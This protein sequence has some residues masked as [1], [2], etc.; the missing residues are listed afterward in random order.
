MEEG[1][2]ISKIEKMSLAQR[3]LIYA[4]TLVFLAGLFVWLVALPK[5]EQIQREKK[6]VARLRERLAQARIRAKDLHK[7]RAE[8]KMIDA[9]FREALRLLPNKKEIPQLLR[10]ITQLGVDSNLEFIYFSPKKER[11]RDF[12]IEIPIEMKVRGRYHD[13]ATFFYKLAKM[14]RIVRILDFSMRPIAENSNVLLAQCS[15][16]TYRFKGN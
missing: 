16:I 13:I 3:I 15:A 4:G 10:N 6:E 7:F 2:F 1:S 8:L 5:H 14:D 9:Q 12:Y 11:L